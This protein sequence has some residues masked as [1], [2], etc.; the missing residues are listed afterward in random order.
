MEGFEI[1]KRSCVSDEYRTVTGVKSLIRCTS[2]C[3]SD[4]G[5]R[6][7]T[8]RAEDQECQI[9]NKDQIIDCILGADDGTVIRYEK[10]E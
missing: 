5:C 7:F 3:V 1:L 10:S 4:D 8:Y 2:F 6:A 9:S